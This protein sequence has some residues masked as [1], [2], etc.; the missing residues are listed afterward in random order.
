MPAVTPYIVG[1]T[2]GIGSGKSTVAELFAAQGVPVVDTDAIAHALTTAS[3]A[4]MAPIGAAFGPTVLTADGALDRAAMR[5]LV[6]ADPEARRRLEAILHPLIRAES[7]RQCAAAVGPY[8]LLVVPLLVES[9]DYARR[10]QRLLVVDCREETQLARVMAR[11][12]LSEGEARAIMAS[13]ASRTERLAAAADVI[14]NDGPASD[15]PPQI[16]RLHQA[17]C[18]AVANVQNEG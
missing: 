3:G 15:L 8:V 14:D 9:G 6:F 18:Q 11:S 12:A 4:G 2:G 10:C 5:R 1:L 16:A 7:A 13:Q 17:Y